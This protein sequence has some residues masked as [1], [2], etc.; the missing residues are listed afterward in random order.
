MA[1]ELEFLQTLSASGVI[2]EISQIDGF[3]QINPKEV[4]EYHQNPDLF[5]ANRAGVSINDWQRWRDHVFKSHESIPLL[6]FLQKRANVHYE[7]APVPIELRW[8]I[9]ERDNFTCKTCGSHKYLSIDH[10]IPL[11][12]G[13]QTVKDNLQTLCNKC[14]S[15]KSNK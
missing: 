6:K 3:I 9:W 1:K 12:K 7:R 2:F 13:G 11:S 10:I 15:K 14:N 8:E 4:L 5:L